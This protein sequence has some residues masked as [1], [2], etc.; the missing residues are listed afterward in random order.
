MKTS[1]PLYLT[2]QQEC[3][4]LDN[5]FARN[6]VCDPEMDF[7]PL[8]YD[9]LLAE[10][11]RRSGCMVYRPNCQHCEECQSSRLPVNE[12]R[13][14]RSQKRAWK[15]VAGHLTVEAKPAAFLEE[16]YQLY[17]KYTANRH[18]DGGMQ[19]S[20]PQDYMS[21]LSCHWAKTYFVELRLDGDLFAVAVTDRQP[22]SLSA[23]YTFFDTDKASMSPGVVAVLAQIE[24]AQRWQLP[25]LYLGF[26]IRESPKMAYKINYQPLEVFRSGQWLK[27]LS[28]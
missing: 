19:N 20:S 22:Q 21:F 8:I 10:G 17:Q 26:W 27:A 18:A 1:I 23:L 11:F 2:Q 13:P 7:D 4:Y 28:E 24:L 25:W 14:N 15:K 3:S 16:H 6:V 12:F 5:R 9:H